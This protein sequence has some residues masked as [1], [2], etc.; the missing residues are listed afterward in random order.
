MALDLGNIQETETEICL[1]K[2]KE[3][4]IGMGRSGRKLLPQFLH[5]LVMI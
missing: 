1:R 5:R 3:G 4:W 2:I